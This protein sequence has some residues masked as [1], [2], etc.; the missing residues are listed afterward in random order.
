MVFE[1][2]DD[3]R[4]WLKP[5]DYVAFWDAVTDWRI[6]TPADRDHCDGLIAKGHVDQE[7]ILTCLKTMARITL[8]QR[9]NLKPRIY[10]PPEAQFLLSVVRDFGTDG[11]LS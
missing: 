6:F 9:L 3:V 5:L 4:E 2:I 10:D 1:D 11:R 7:L 8:M